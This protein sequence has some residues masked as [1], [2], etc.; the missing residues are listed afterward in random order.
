MFQ[1]ENMSLIR[2]SAGLGVFGLRDIEILAEAC[3][4]QYGAALAKVHAWLGAGV[5]IEDIYL[6]G[7][8]AAARLLGEW[9]LSDRIDFVKVTIGVHCLQQ[10]LYELSPQF[11]Q[12][13]NQKFN[14]YR[15]IFFSTPNSQHGFGSVMVAE[16]FRREG[17]KVSNVAPESESDVVR[18]LTQQWFE[19]VGF[20]VCSDRGW[21]ALKSLILKARQVSLNPNVQIMIGG[22][23][24][25]L[26]P[27]LAAVLGADLI[28]G[29]AR[30]SQRLAR[31]NIKRL[32]LAA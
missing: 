8:A 27:D 28:G 7:L 5:D 23:M 22:P 11:L 15:A 4:C 12:R 14:G 10:I 3:I 17:W 26:N 24:V 20:S 2:A 30:V 16:F 25:D 18:E 6:D 9:W 19:V 13:A 1:Q 32:E 31:Q 29:D 21:P